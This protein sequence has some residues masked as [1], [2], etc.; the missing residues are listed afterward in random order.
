MAL[1]TIR[2]PR[3]K[4]LNL[5]Q[6]AIQALR[7][8]TGPNL[9]DGLQGVFQGTGIYGFPRMSQADGFYFSMQTASYAA[10][11]GMSPNVRIVTG[12]MLDAFMSADLVAVDAK[13]S[14]DDLDSA[15]RSVAHPN[16]GQAGSAWR[17]AMALDLLVFDN[18]YSIIISE[19]V[20]DTVSLVHV[21]AWAIGVG[22][23]NKLFPDSYR[24]QLADGTF[25]DYPADQI[26]HIHGPNPS[27]PRLGLS[28]LETLRQNLIEDQ[29]R[30]ANNIDTNRSGGM[31][32]GVIQRPAEAPRLDD[33][34]ADRIETSIWNKLQ[35]VVKGRVALLDEGM[36]F[37]TAGMTLA[38]AEVIAM[39]QASLAEVC[40]CYGVHPD[41]IGA[42]QQSTSMP[43]ARKQLREDTLPPMFQRFADGLTHQ[44]TEETF[45]DRTHFEF[46]TRQS[47][48]EKLDAIG[49]AAQA[50]GRPPLTLNEARS[51]LLNYPPVDGGDVHVL[52]SG[53]LEEGAAGAGQ[54]EN[55]KPTPETPGIPD[56]TTPPQDGSGRAGDP[57]AAKSIE[58]MKTAVI[59]NLKA[60][61]DAAT[62]SQPGPDK[63]KAIK[64]QVMERRRNGYADDI[65]SVVKTHL[66]RQRKALGQGKAMNA[67]TDRWNRELAADLLP[68]YKSSVQAEGEAVSVGLVNSDG[69]AS[70]FDMAYTEH[71]LEAGS[72]AAAK[73]FNTATQNS[74]DA[75]YAAEDDGETDDP[76]GRAFDARDG[77][78]KGFALAVA[79][80]LA[81]FAAKEAGRQN[82][83]ESRMKR[84]VWS[85]LGD[86]HSDM[87]GEA[88]ALDDAFSN[89][90]QYPGDPA[91]GPAENANCGCTVEVF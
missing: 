64:Q 60:S 27:D 34:G 43:E 33:N 16:V 17:E 68:V 79:T 58:A 23:V 20:L 52:P 76:V 87:D 37:V 53:V 11:W 59:E 61:A 44:L 74:V 86:R 56:P 38:Q 25:S 21:P 46:R 66:E 15:G 70:V 47:L 71:Y 30:R 29:T 49:Q 28:K 75:G 91:G 45:A 85:G 1:P 89:D 19:A 10:L 80:G 32:G 31:R 50:A 22:G 54:G 83:P 18:C 13:G 41:V 57:P 6:G 40:H 2:I 62:K 42:Y 69:S 36:T 4:G 82:T 55:E 8:S 77:E 7:G 78:A 48:A 24:V 35:G 14:V 26:V 12:A 73:G 51:D 5:T 65:E 88:V 72:K 39:S 84:W 81:G 9:P 67:D 63:G 3:R 90:L